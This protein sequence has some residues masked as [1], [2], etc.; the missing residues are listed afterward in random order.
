MRWSHKINIMNTFLNKI[1]KNSHKLRFTY[2]FT[3]RLMTHFIILTIYTSE[4]TSRKENSS[5]SLFAAYARFFPEMRCCTGN[6]EFFTDTAY[7][8]YFTSINQTSSR[9]NRTFHDKTSLFTVYIH[10]IQLFL[11]KAR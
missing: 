1:I 4:I 3:E 9:T 5:R 11:I 2:F 7:T 6:S 10:I 8:V